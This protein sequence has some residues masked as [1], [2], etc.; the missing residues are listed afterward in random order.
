M[1]GIEKVRKRISPDLFKNKT[2]AQYLSRADVV[3]L[4]ATSSFMIW[5]NYL[6]NY[7]SQAQNSVDHNK[8]Q[9][10]N[11]Y[12]VYLLNRALDTLQIIGQLLTHLRQIMEYRKPGVDWIN[13]MEKKLTECEQDQIYDQQRKL[14][15]QKLVALH[16]NVSFEGVETTYNDEVI[17]LYHNAFRDFPDLKISK[18]HEGFGNW[19]RK[20]FHSK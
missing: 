3:V 13:D 15:D 9:T 16:T 20:K 19:L 17:N 11:D 18:H 10:V 6:K 7:N 2:L 1:E 12:Y 5:R 14:M 4:S 8:K